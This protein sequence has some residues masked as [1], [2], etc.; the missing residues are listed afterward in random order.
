MRLAQ[1]HPA[2]SIWPGRAGHRAA[3]HPAIAGL[4]RA[5]ERPVATTGGDAAA[6]SPDG[7]AAAALGHAGTAG[8]EPAWGGQ[9]GPGDGG[10]GHGPAARAGAGGMAP[11]GAAH[12]PV[13]VARTATAGRRRLG[14]RGGPAL[15]EP[16]RQHPAAHLGSRGPSGGACASA[17][18]A[19]DAL[20]GSGRAGAR[21]VGPGPT[22]A[23]TANGA[24]AAV[25]APA[26]GAHRRPCPGLPQPWHSRTPAPRSRRNQWWQPGAGPAGRRGGSSP[27]PALRPLQQPG[28]SLL[29]L[30][31]LPG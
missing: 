21:A 20:A 28:P 24:V 13:A 16:D 12:Q 2:G 17:A 5:L 8:A 25:C 23:A 30:W 31:R 9:P 29:G 3:P 14:S 22:M 26:R 15:A 1:R 6:G 11:G 7:L 27:G 18:A 10:W 19:C 4:Q